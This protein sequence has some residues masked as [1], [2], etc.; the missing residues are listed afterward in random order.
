[1]EFGGDSLRMIEKKMGYN[2][3]KSIASFP[4]M[5][6]DGVALEVQ[7]QFNQLGGNDLLAQYTLLS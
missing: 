2:F 4:V 1:M 7:V 5:V 3:P 6:L